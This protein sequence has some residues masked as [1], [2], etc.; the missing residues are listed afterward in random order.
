MILDAS[1]RAHAPAMPPQVQAVMPSA[2]APVGPVRASAQ[3]SALAPAPSASLAPAAASAASAVASAPALAQAVAPASAAASTSLTVAAPALPT[4]PDKPNAEELL[5]MQFTAAF[6]D[7]SKPKAR[8]HARRKLPWSVFV[9][10]QDAIGTFLPSH[11]KADNEMNKSEILSKAQNNKQSFNKQRAS[12]TCTFCKRF[13]HL[14][15]QCFKKRRQQASI[16]QR[17]PDTATRTGH[18]QEAASASTISGQSK[19]TVAANV[20]ELSTA[21]SA[22]LS[23]TPCPLL[24]KQMSFKLLAL[25]KRLSLKVLLD[26]GATNCFISRQQVP[27]HMLS[28]LDEMVSSKRCID[29]ISEQERRVQN[30]FDWQRDKVQIALVEFEMNGSSFKHSIVLSDAIRNEP[31]IIG[32]DSYKQHSASNNHADDSMRLGNADYF[33]IDTDDGVLSKSV[34][35]GSN[36]CKMLASALTHDS[37]PVRPEKCRAL[38]TISSIDEPDVAEISNSEPD[39]ISATETE[40]EKQISKPITSLVKLKFGTAR[41]HRQPWPSQWSAASAVQPTRR[42]RAQTRPGK[43]SVPRHHFHLLRPHYSSNVGNPDST[44]PSASEAPVDSAPGPFQ[45]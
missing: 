35:N 11:F 2:T 1:A 33:S 29:L 25:G 4:V 31:A 6:P 10:A 39:C 23:L 38:G 22:P 15:A 34:T 21:G 18:R 40:A 19:A 41:H 32:R 30:V 5:R 3:S 13:G 44:A 14:E 26:M 45:L 24:R 20:V 17:G 36:V 12:V 16:K 9:D 42:L 43:S 28:K 37:Q 27:I 8:A 7:S